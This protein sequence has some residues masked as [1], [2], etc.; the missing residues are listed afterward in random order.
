MVKMNA[1]VGDK[2]REEKRAQEGKPLDTTGIKPATTGVVSKPGD[3]PGLAA[4]P[5]EVSPASKM[6][7]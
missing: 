3:M 4:K 7:N 2:A 5:A 6:A 1:A